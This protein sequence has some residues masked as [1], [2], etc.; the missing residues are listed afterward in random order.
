MHYENYRGLQVH[1][2]I[3]ANSL[4]GSKESL[5]LLLSVISSHQWTLN[6]TDIQAAFLQNKD[7]DFDMYIV[8]PAETNCKNFLRKLGKCLY[9]LN[10][11]V[12]SWYFFTAEFLDNLKC[13]RSLVS[14]GLFAWY[15]N[16]YLP[17]FSSHVYN[18]LN[19]KNLT[20]IEKIIEPF[21][22]KSEIRQP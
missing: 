10:D 3:Q 21:C 6:S 18:F 19:A 7:I 12:C 4:T 8:T 15:E 13:H 5:R 9:G 22:K 16:E 2:E 14:Y 1:S 20:F 11:A 17:R